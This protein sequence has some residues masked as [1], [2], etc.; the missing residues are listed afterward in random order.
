MTLT[1]GG[2]KSRVQKCSAPWLPDK[3][4]DCKLE[5]RSRLLLPREIQRWNGAG[6]TQERGGKVYDLVTSGSLVP[7][8]TAT[9]GHPHPSSLAIRRLG[10]KWRLSLVPS[11]LSRT[12]D[13]QLLSAWVCLGSSIWDVHWDTLHDVVLA[14]ERLGH[15]ERKIEDDLP[16]LA[17]NNVSHLWI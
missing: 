8:S 17:H 15:L 12:S 16:H 3:P 9:S 5:G 11:W 1:W 7:A 6:L 2:N 13:C 4:S 14:T 10:S